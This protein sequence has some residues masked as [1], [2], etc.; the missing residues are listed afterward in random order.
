MRAGTRARTERSRIKSGAVGEGHSGCARWLRSINDLSIGFFA[1]L[2][3]GFRGNGLA[4]SAALLT[5]FIGSSSTTIQ[6]LL[7][8]YGGVCSGGTTGVLACRAGG[9]NVFRVERIYRREGATGVRFA[10]IGPG[11]RRGLQDGV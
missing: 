11:G 5:E 9:R 8:L 10:R 1:P 4:Q 7:K 6:E 2:E 3:S